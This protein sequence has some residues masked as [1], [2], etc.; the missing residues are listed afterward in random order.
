MSDR[1]CPDC[2]SNLAPVHMVDR[3][4]GD[5]HHEMMYAST[6]PQG[7]FVSYLFEGLIK[8]FMCGVCG[9]ILLY[10]EPI[11]S[12]DEPPKPAP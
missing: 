10:G 6:E 9:R 1:K 7:W 3:G 2:Q 4:D 11:P 12:D 8:G 5:A